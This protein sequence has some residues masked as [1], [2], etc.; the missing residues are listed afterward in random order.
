MY[1]V[2]YLPNCV[3]KRFPGIVGKVG[4]SKQSIDRR[5]RDN[6]SYGYDVTGR[7]VFADN[8][9]EQDAYWLEAELQILYNCV[10]DQS[11]FNIELR[12]DPKFIAKMKPVYE[13]RSKNHDWSKIA[14]QNAKKIPVTVILANGIE[15][16]FASIAL[17]AKSLEISL[18]R[19]HNLF[20]N[21]GRA[22]K[23]SIKGVRIIPT[24]D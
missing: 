9:S 20:K 24:V 18:P 23:G 19:A 15:I 11:I 22:T 1:H 14:S 17:A 3:R 4:Q 5:L 2:Y 10:E 6:E 8:L 7:H 16:N 13:A 12:K 21:K